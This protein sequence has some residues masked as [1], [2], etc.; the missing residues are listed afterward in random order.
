MSAVLDVS[1]PTPL[2]LF[3]FL[4]TA[5]GGLLIAYGAIT[6]WA[7]V[8]F[9][10]GTFPDSATKGVDVLEG[11]VALGLGIVLLVAIV[12]MR[13]AHTVGGRRLLALIVVVA[14]ACALA[15][16]VADVLRAEGRFGGFAV[17]ENA[18]LISDETGTP[19]DQVRAGLQTVIDENASIEL[20]MGIW[21]VVAGG[22]IGVIGGLLDLAWVG[23]Q[24]LQ[25][26]GEEVDATS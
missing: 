1:R 21:L 6:D 10:G 3:G 23:Q 18:K 16:G 26:L 19:I 2:R 5:I 22:G 15:I 14:A 17:D 11:K 20:G 8:V 25:N 9:L 12:T 24:R 7:T 4:F 13:L